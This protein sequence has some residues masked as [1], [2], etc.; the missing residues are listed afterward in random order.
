M[1]R[2]EAVFLSIIVAL[3]V[4]PATIV[5]S[6]YKVTKNPNLRPLSITAES[7]AAVPDSTGA[8]R[9]IIVTIAS[10]T[11]TDPSTHAKLE[12][13]LIRAFDSFLLKPVI[14]HTVGTENSATIAYQVGANTVGPMPLSQAASGLRLAVDAD[15]RRTN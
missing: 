10:P 7:L 9:Q 11:G 13:D 5:L 3:V 14:V 15:R 6:I 2:S 8:T 4:T 1:K 12:S